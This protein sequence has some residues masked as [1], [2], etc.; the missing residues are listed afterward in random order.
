MVLSELLD[1]FL[2]RVVRQPALD[3]KHRAAQRRIRGE[4]RMGQPRGGNEQ[5]EI[6]DE[7]HEPAPPGGKPALFAVK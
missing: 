4:K 5:R 1:G 7:K 6:R 3:H 2:Q